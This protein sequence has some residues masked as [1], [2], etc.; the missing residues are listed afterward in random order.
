ML[1]AD[2]SSAQ[3][4][5]LRATN[6][7]PDS[8]T[9]SFAQKESLFDDAL[10]SGTSSLEEIAGT[11]RDDL[12]GVSETTRAFAESAIAEETEALLAKYEERRK[13]LLQNVDEERRVIEGELGRISDLADKYA[14]SKAQRD[15]SMRGKVMSGVAGVFS[16]A[17]VLF[18][19]SGVV[20]ND[21]GA[22]GNAAVDAVCA[23][24][25]VYFLQREKEQKRETGTK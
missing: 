24:A 19:F 14:K 25:A 4:N 17:A 10:S 1:S 12:K 13:E 16:I 11:V 15:I 3:D 22:L 9:P 18:A 23:A 2:A 5:S 8:A 7:L 20:D 21:S 6:G